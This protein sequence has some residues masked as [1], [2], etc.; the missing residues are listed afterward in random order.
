M[1]PEAKSIKILKVTQSLAKMLEFDVPE[2]ERI[3]RTEPPEKLFTLV[4]G[5][6][7]DVT[8]RIIKKL[9][10]PEEDVLFCA[11]F[12]DSYK[13]T[14]RLNLLDDYNLLIGAVAYYL[15]NSPGSASVLVESVRE[16]DLNLEGE[17][18]EHALYWLL[19]GKY[20]VR[21]YEDSIYRNELESFEA[22]TSFFFNSGSGE[23]DLFDIC[24][25]LKEKVDCYGSPRETFL[26]NLLYA[27]CILKVK[28]SCWKNLPVFSG[29][30][31]DAW[32]FIIKKKGFIKE[33]WPAQ[34]KI[35]EQGVFR[36][37][38]AVLQMPTSAGK[39]K[40]TEIIIRSAFLANRIDLAVIVAP[41]RS[42]CHEIK[43]DFFKCFRGE[44]D[45]TIDE[46]TDALISE[47]ANVFLN[48]GK[49][50]V[51]VTPEKLYYLLTQN[52]EFVSRVGLVIYD[53]GHQ[54]DAGKRGVTYELLLTE[55]KQLLVKDIQ[56]VLVSAVISNADE[57]ARWLSPK[58]VV[59]HG[60]SNL[61]T[62]RN[63]AYVD[64]ASLNFF[65]EKNVF[66]NEFFAPRIIREKNLPLK[67]KER[68]QRKFPDL[69]DSDSITFYLALK[70]S[71]FKC[72]AVFMGKKTSVRPFL[73]YINDIYSRLPLES[74]PPC[75]KDEQIKILNIVNLNLGTDNALFKA[76]RNGIFAH[77]ANIPQGIRLSVENAVHEELVNF[78]VCT[79][80]LAQGVNL[81]IKN[82]FVLS[83]YQ[84]KEPIKVRDFHNL[85]GRVARSGKMTEGN[86]IFTDVEIARDGRKKLMIN[87]MIAPERAERC[88]SMIKELIKEFIDCY[89]SVVRR[90]FS[91][92]IKLS[93]LLKYYISEKNADWVANEI[94]KGENA[95]SVRN[96]FSKI[97]QKRFNYL[98]TIDNFLCNCCGEVDELNVIE[99]VNKTY[100]Y[101]NCSSQEDRDKIVY[102]FEI[103]KENILEKKLEK[104]R[105]KRL[106]H[107]LRGLNVALSVEKFVNDN[108]FILENVESCQ[109]FVSII[110]GLFVEKFFP[111]KIF[112][113][114]PNREKLLHAIQCWVNGNSYAYLFDIL[115][116]EV[117]GSRKVTLEHVVEI[118]DG[119]LSYDGS[120][121]VNSIV[122]ILIGD[123]PNQDLLKKIQLYQKQIKYGLPNIESIVLYEIGFCDRTLA[124]K[125]ST[126]FKGIETK[127]DM[128]RQLLVDDVKVKRILSE[129]PS[130]FEKK[131]YERLL[132]KS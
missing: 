24:K 30:P 73:D 26:C 106:S 43:N 104:D 86:V 125:L 74:K 31:K 10:I 119:C 121:L 36:G 132:Y 82:L 78:L 44:K 50:I 4:I 32:S 39:T 83:L 40:S 120:V 116:D 48:E 54:F 84:D 87:K 85:M 97:L 131:V 67:G 81:P 117:I 114:Y 90:R 38:S 76:A 14:G 80:T 109:S 91:V 22:K 127:E 13:N 9:E 11:R 110:S 103:L 55:L 3:L 66:E 1:K 124:L 115:K 65:N 129:Y 61:P 88:D 16:D 21:K 60:S 130:Y 93:D 7:G 8:R 98:E 52:K 5:I 23:E 123:V 128:L 28:N 112:Y 108:R 57:I 100:A 41:F 53:E 17:K 72:V 99:L 51:I 94:C 49:H 75:I 62:R 122:E 118:F 101:E 89:D 15:S 79:T 45:I 102:L 68:N 111:K 69:S 113:G 58:C 71:Q 34:R 70:Q 56:I 18:I 47:D 37:A 126:L 12:F 42:L 64:G 2:E 25:A 20:N 59:V 77:H 46:I 63:L 105:L 95:S 96:D 35:G 33:L 6:L 92:P 107:T 27:V 19:K 29:L